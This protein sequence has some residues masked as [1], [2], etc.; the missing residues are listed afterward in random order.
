L[1]ALVAAV[2]VTACGTPGT[3]EKPPLTEEQKAFGPTGIPPHLRARTPADPVGAV[4]APGGNKR[5]TA[6]LRLTPIEDIIFTKGD[7]ADQQLPELAELLAAPKPKIWEDSETIARRRSAR[8]GKPLLI[9]FTSSKFSP[10]CKALEQE[11]FGRQ[12]FGDWATEK[13][14]RLRVDA[15]Y[16]ATDPNL[17]MK[18]KDDRE[19]KAKHYAAE[20]KKRYKVMGHPT[21]VL[22]N[23]SGEVLG[24]WAGYKRGTADFTWGL[25]KHGE[26]V[27]TTAYQSW[28]AGM[29]KKGYREWQ[30]RLGRKIFARLVSYDDG[31]LI[32]VD[33]DGSRFRTHEDKL[34]DANRAWITEQKEIRRLP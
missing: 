29:E 17:S 9:W 8:E 24:R 26:S 11:L 31:E 20:L 19:I 12:D 5:N 7:S 18:E 28:R 34:C 25:L 30:D 16:Q 21:L 27:S 3:V 2:A 23:P 1:G 13:L 14:V 10:N 6:G 4:V 33:P 32:L 22:L 15:T